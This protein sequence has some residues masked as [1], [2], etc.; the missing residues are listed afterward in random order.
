MCNKSY[1]NKRKETNGGQGGDEQEGWVRRRAVG[2][3]N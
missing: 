1:I 3:E 2:K